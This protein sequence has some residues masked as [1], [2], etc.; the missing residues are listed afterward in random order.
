MINLSRFPVENIVQG[1]QWITWTDVISFPAEFLKGDD[2]DFG[3][4]AVN[5]METD[6]DVSIDSFEISLPPKEYYPDPEA[7]CDELIV[8]GDSSFSPFYTYPIF[9]HDPQEKFHISSDASGNYIT[10]NDCKHF[11]SGPTVQLIPGKFK[12]Q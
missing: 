2:E 6:V 1:G 5:G 4:I 10:M 9:S 11:F 8:N 7:V 3:A 12:K